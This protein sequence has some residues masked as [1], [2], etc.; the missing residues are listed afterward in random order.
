MS[1]FDDLGKAKIMRTLNAPIVRNWRINVAI[2][3]ALLIFLLARPSR[4]VAQTAGLVAAYSFN[5]GSGTTVSDSSGNNLTGIIV[6]ASWTTGGR[7]GNALSFNGSSSYVDLGNPTALQLTGSMTLEAWINAAVNPADDGQIVAKSDGTGGWQ[8][9]TSPDT[10]PHTFGVAVSGSSGSNV[11]RYSTT[12]RSLNTWYHVAGVYNATTGTLDIYVNGVLDDGTL[13]GTIP[14]GQVNQTVNVNI[15]RRTGGFYF[16]GIID[17]V[18]I[19]NRALSQAEIQTDMNTPIGSGTPPDTTPPTAPS[20]LTATPASPTQINVSWTASTDN[21]GVTGYRVERCQGASCSNFAQI[22]TP[23][24]TTFNDTGLLGSTSYSYRV[25]ATDAANNLSM[26]SNTA[27]ATT[28]APTFTAP[29]NLTATASGSTQI[30][31]SWTAAAETGGTIS[32]YLVERC[33]G[34]NCSNFAQVGT[35]ATAT[36]GDTGVIGSTSY[37][38]RVR[39][40]DAS[41]N[42]GPYSNTASVTTPVNTPSAPTNLTATASG[43]VQINLSWTASTETAGTIANYLIERCSVGN[44]LNFVQVGTS[45]AT[46]FSDAGLTGSTSY[47]YRVRAIDT[48]NVTGPYSNTASATTAAPTFTA[49]SGLTA[50]PAGPVQINLAWT[51]ATETGGMISQYLIERCTGAVCSNFVQVG[52]SALT[53]FSNAGLLGSTSYSYRVRATDAANNLSTYSNAASATTASPTFTP[54]SNLTSM[55]VGSTQINL[56]WTAGTETGGTITQYLIERCQGSG[57]SS[58]TQVAT[59]A[60]SAFNDTGLLAG[61]TYGY[62]VR[63]TDTANNFSP[64]SNVA[65]ATTTTTPPPPIAFVQRNFAVPQTLQITVSVAYTLAQSIGDLNIVAVG[66]N[67]SAAAV[68]SVRDTSG[69][70]YVLAVGPTVQPGIATQAIYYAKNISAAAAGA[71]TVTVTF[72]TSATNPD[73]RIAEYS[74]IDTVNPLDVAVAA[75]GNSATSNSGS[76][77]TTNANDLLVGANLVQTLTSGPGTGYTSRV[78]TSPDGDIFED[79]VVTTIGSYASTAPV[80]PSGPWIMQLVAFKRHP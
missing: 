19:Y 59:S 2:L 45:A 72:T 36:F 27:S 37:S 63:A 29:S 15:G 57:C 60:T 23:A 78:I 6:G 76:V 58:F 8:F 3:L 73:I 65:S 69:N 4:V 64:Y 30:N 42:L 22:A 77:P 26:Y 48:T 25:R 39:A 51:A 74:G 71:N 11:Q 67:D 49:P 24:S 52:T 54:P 10:G 46:T 28:A 7:Y 40:T 20:G 62:R 75:Q 34:P 9:K 56:A 1:L 5:E 35:S 18:R 68:G 79:R 12:V 70:A 14:T 47:S 32:Q 55:S 44:C 80:S 43:P 17:E 61:T 16:N 38:Y 31:L 41:N 21:V 13:R 53:A 50:T 66:W 33:P